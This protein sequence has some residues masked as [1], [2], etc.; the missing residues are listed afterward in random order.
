MK[1][2]FNEASIVDAKIETY[3][4]LWNSSFNGSELYRIQKKGNIY[5]AIRKVYLNHADSIGTLEKLEF[6]EDHWIRITEELKSNGFWTYKNTIDKQ[7]LDGANWSI[8][9]YSPLKTNAALKTFIWYQG[10]LQRTAHSSKC[11]I[12]F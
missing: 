4:F 12:Y 1:S 5:I 11:T 3:Q 8:S 9:A 2:D 6:S 10:G 7:G